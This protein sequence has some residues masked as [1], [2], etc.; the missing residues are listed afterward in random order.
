MKADDILME[1]SKCSIL[2]SISMARPDMSSETIVQRCI[3]NYNG[4]PTAK[5]V[6]TQFKIYIELKVFNALLHLGGI[7]GDHAGK[8]SGKF[9]LGKVDCPVF[10]LTNNVLDYI[11]DI[12]S[13]LGEARSGYVEKCY[14]IIPPWVAGLIPKNVMH[15]NRDTVSANGYLGKVSKIDMDIFASN[16]LPNGYIFFGTQC[17]MLFDI[18]IRGNIATY[19]YGLSVPE[20]FGELYCMKYSGE[21]D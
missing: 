7:R 13:V 11:A 4:S 10:L 8:E 12:E 18:D 19:Q 15:S 21:D 2:P 14:C 9:N 16:C 1:F 17:A 3:F 6:A 20:R 5:D